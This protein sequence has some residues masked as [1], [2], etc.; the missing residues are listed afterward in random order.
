LIA[1]LERLA[2]REKE[3]AELR[4]RIEQSEKHEQES[5][6]TIEELRKTIEELQS[7]EL[8]ME[9]RRLHLR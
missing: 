7:L 9:Q 4:T 8:Q 3:T 6:K 5:R 2:A 1:I